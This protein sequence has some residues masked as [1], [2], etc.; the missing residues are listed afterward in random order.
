MAVATAIA[1]VDGG[2]RSVIAD[3]LG[4]II[5]TVDKAG[6]VTDCDR[7]LGCGALW[8]WREKR[9]FDVGVR[10]HFWTWQDDLVWSLA[11]SIK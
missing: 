2:G 8:W 1:A 6:E 7:G 4:R 9:T 10:I 3:R 5:V 11:T